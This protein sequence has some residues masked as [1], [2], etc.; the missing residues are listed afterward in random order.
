MTYTGS[1]KGGDDLAFSAVPE[2]EL[3]SV[4]QPEMAAKGRVH[5]ISNSGNTT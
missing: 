4:D 5:E 1:W 2:S 3:R